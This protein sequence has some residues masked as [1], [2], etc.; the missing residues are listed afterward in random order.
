MS[1]NLFLL[2]RWLVALRSINVCCFLRLSG[3]TTLETYIIATSD[4]VLITFL[5]GF[6]SGKNA[7]R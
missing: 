6:V 4:R 2:V 7:R 1:V 5:N 3:P